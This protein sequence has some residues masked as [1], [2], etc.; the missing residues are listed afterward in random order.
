MAETSLDERFTE[1]RRAV[2]EEVGRVKRELIR[3]LANAL[4]RM[5]AAS[6]ESE[7]N[8]AVMESGRP[9]S[10]DPAALEFLSTLAALTTPTRMENVASNGANPAAQRFAR[11]KVAE[12]QLYHASSVKAGRV[13]K[14]LYGCL[15]PQIDSAR[16]AYQDSFLMPGHETP[17]YIHVELVRAL[18]NDDATLLGPGYPG[19]LA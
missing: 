2:D 17:D 5:R 9:F 12:I 10:D 4:A 3:E 15:K 11:V 18:A 7:W 8:A 13:A 6:N 19:P 16:Q 1:L 14:D